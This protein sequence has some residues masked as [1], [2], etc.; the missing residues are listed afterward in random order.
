MLLFHDGAVHVPPNV[1][2]NVP[3]FVPLA[4]PHVPVPP[5]FFS[6]I[7]LSAAVPV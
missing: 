2:A 6:V 7:I 4:P 3:S 5:F 1:H